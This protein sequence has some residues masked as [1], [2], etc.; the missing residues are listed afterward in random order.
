MPNGLANE[1]DAH[2][3]DLK[4]H[5]IQTLKRK[6]KDLE[7]RVDAEVA[8]ILGYLNDFEERIQKL[9]KKARMQ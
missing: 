6:V 9:E 7:E 8:N 4:A 2:K 1:F 3:R 5:N